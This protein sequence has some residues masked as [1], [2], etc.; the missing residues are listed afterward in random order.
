MEVISPENQ[1]AL[2]SRYQMTA[3]VITAQIVFTV[4]VTAAVW[5]IAP[6]NHKSV[7]PQ[8][9]T[10]LWTAIFFLAIGA[11]VLRRLFFR[12]D[13]LK[14]IVLLKG[15]AGLIGTLQRNAILLAVFATLLPIIGAVI[16]VLS[17]ATF[18]VIRAEIVALIVFI[19]NFPRQSV[20]RKIIIGM[21]KI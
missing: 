21:E 4:A 6:S 16:S 13:R 20:W 2:E 12:W 3:K 9:V 8:T 15:I 7:S 17:G 1:A 5:F 10:T 18:E 14:D 11:F 19:I